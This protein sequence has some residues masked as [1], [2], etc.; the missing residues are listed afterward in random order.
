MLEAH[1]LRVVLLTELEKSDEAL[2]ACHPKAWKDDPPMALKARAA[3]VVAQRGFFRH[4]ISRMKRAMREDPDY[5]WG[6]K[7]LAEWHRAVQSNAGYL[8][9]AQRLIQLAPHEPDS[10]GYLGDAKMRAG[11][12]KAAKAAFHE[13]FQMDPNY[14]FVAETLY[15]MRL[16]DGELV[17]AE[18]MLNRIRN[19]SARDRVKKWEERLIQR[20][21]EKMAPWKAL[22]ITASAV[23]FILCAVLWFRGNLSDAA[24]LI[25]A[26]SLSGGIHILLRFM[27][28]KITT[29]Q[30]R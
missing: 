30:V 7:Q 14:E 26:A 17:E 9:A 3:W 22:A 10:F 12:R 25:I 27:E 20:R 29:L 2:Q 19:A 4:A 13:A 1:L 28:K 11:D 21:R 23:L 15:S 24:A 18:S 16:Q 8:E 6:W 5:V